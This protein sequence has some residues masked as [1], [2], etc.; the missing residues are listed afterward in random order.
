MWPHVPVQ[1]C[2]WHVPRALRWALDADQA[3]HRWA[4]T[5]RLDLIELLRRSAREHHPLEQ[6]LPDDDRFRASTG[7]HHAAGGLLEGARE[8]VFTCL[9]PDLRQRLAALG[10]PEMGSGVLE[11]G[12]RESNARTDVAAAAGLPQDH[13]TSSPSSPQDRTPRIDH[14][15]RPPSTT[16]RHPLQ[17]PNGDVHRWLTPPSR[18]RAHRLRARLRLE[19]DLGGATAHGEGDDEAHCGGNVLR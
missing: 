10:G 3:D 11:R 5:K 4:D 13:A 7:A 9:G 19:L 6:A 18:E 16:Q 2:W 14:T 12:M 17:P 1:R 15:A 8:Q